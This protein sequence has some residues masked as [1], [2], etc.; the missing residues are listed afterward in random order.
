[1]DN[2]LQEHLELQMINRL[3]GTDFFG[4]TANDEMYIDDYN[5]VHTP[6]TY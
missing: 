4:Y 2:G 3:D 6:Y 5:I 1:M